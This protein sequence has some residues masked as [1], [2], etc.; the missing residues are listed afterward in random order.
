MDKFEEI[1]LWHHG[2]YSLYGKHQSWLIEELTRLRAENDALRS[3]VER[4]GKIEDVARSIKLRMN[5]GVVHI[6]R[7]DI[8]RL[9][10]VLCDNPRP[11]VT[12]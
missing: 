4:R 8:L 7:D 10:E 11:E 5:G 2:G 12:S 6:P 1:K 3:E 9:D